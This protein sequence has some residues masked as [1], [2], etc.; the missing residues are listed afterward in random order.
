MQNTLLHNFHEQH[1]KGKPPGAIVE[2]EIVLL[3]RLTNSV[4]D[5][6]NTAST[7]VYIRSMTLKHIYEKRTAYKYDVILESLTAIIETPSSVYK[8]N[9]T[10]RA[11]YI[12]V[13]TIKGA[14]FACLLQENAHPEVGQEV[15]VVVTAY[16]TTKKY[17]EK[18]E[19]IQSWKDG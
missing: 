6:L 18:F 14:L 12:L 9:S 16:R 13:K 19:H 5:A 3:A 10:K 2:V 7:K 1:V 4:A 11:H 8:N 17:L 15:T